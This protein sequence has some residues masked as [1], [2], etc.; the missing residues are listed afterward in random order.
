MVE[1]V[2]RVIYNMQ[3]FCRLY[4]GMI[5]ELDIKELGKAEVIV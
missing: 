3:V 2:V 1:R 5:K 4:T